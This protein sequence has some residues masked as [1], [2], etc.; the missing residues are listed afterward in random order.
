MQ[1]IQFMVTSLSLTAVSIFNGRGSLDFTKC[2]RTHSDASDDP[3]KWSQIKETG[4]CPE[5]EE[6]QIEK[7]ETWILDASMRMV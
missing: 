1:R 6:C 5:T 3:V 7:G 4:R 2:L